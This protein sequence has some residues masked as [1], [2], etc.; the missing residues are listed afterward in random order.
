MG[1]EQMA[2]RVES[3]NDVFKELHKVFKA[4]RERE[5]RSAA[6]VPGSRHPVAAVQPMT[7]GMAP[8]TAPT[9]VLV[10]LSLLSGV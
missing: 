3:R 7:G 5:S 9:Q 10:M 4:E 1:L 8:T 2:P 6:L